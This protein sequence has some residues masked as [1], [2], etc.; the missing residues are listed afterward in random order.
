MANGTNTVIVMWR[1]LFYLHY[2]SRL[3]YL[4]MYCKR[5]PFLKIQKS[6]IY[7]YVM[8]FKLASRHDVDHSYNWC[9]HITGICAETEAEI[10]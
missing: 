3:I 9:I 1:A 5:T 4:L 2:P 8:G 7:A 10:S 6:K